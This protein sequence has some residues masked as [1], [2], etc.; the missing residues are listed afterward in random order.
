[1]RF[2]WCVLKVLMWVHM[3]GMP[4]VVMGYFLAATY[5]GRSL[6]QL[7]WTR[8]VVH[9]IAVLLMIGLMIY[10]VIHDVLCG[11]KRVGMLSEQGVSRFWLMALIGGGSSMLWWSVFVVF[12]MGGLGYG[13]GV[14]VFVVWLLTAVVTM[15]MLRWSHY[16]GWYHGG[17]A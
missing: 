14:M 6:D 7:G 10:V 9:L 13:G 16:I 15:G 12:M 8:M 4:T 2:I 11:G 1:M 3:M 5:S 17:K